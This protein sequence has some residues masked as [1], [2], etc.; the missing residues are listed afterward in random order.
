V[1]AAAAPGLNLIQPTAARSYAAAVHR[2]LSPKDSDPLLKLEC[3]VI[4]FLRA[5]HDAHFACDGKC[6][7]LA[8]LCDTPKTAPAAAAAPSPVFIASPAQIGQ[9]PA[10]AAA[11]KIPAS[12]K[13]QAET[14]I[15]YPSSPVVVA[16]P[17]STSFTASGSVVTA[18]APPTDSKRSTSVP[19]SD[20]ATKIA[21]HAAPTSSSTVPTQADFALFSSTPVK[22]VSS[23]LKMAS[24]AL[25]RKKSPTPTKV[26]PKSSEGVPPQDVASKRANKRKR[27]KTNT[28]KKVASTVDYAVADP[29]VLRRVFCTGS[30][31]PSAEAIKFMHD[32][33]KVGRLGDLVSLLDGSA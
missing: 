22:P 30:L 11:P 32:F 5:F 21:V 3:R 7:C 31:E 12:S 28:L 25:K 2:K 33:A 27:Q 4:A 19:K 14:K 20:V 8:A 16:A 6:Q 29:T 1:P 10:A 23:A 9:V 17:S 24:S 26:H 13:T 18:A 15:D